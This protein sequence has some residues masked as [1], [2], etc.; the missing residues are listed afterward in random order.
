VGASA[1][2]T[3]ISATLASFT[4]TSRAPAIAT[5]PTLFADL[6]ETEPL[7]PTRG[8]STKPVV[9]TSRLAGYVGFFTGLGALLAVFGFLRLPPLFA[10][11]YSNEEPLLA[12]QKGIV[13]SFY[14]VAIVA[15]LVAVF[16]ALTLARAPV[17]TARETDYE[18]LEANVSL[19]SRSLKLTKSLLTGFSIGAKDAEVALAYVTGFAVR[20]S[21][22]FLGLMRGGC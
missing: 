9:G 1:L 2:T 7:I 4:A 16:T 11:L 6:P 12:L 8:P 10:D 17:T 18:Q 13:D 3:M 19:A 14:V 15:L 20:L 22:T 21:R 5:P